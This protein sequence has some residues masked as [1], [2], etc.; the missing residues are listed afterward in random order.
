[1]LADVLAVEERV[2]AYLG[3]ARSRKTHTIVGLGFRWWGMFGGKGRNG[4]MMG[5]ELD[6]AF[7]LVEKW[8]IG[9]DGVTPPICPQELMLRWPT[10]AI[11]LRTRPTIDMIDGFTWTARHCGR[12][13]RNLT[14]R[15]IQIALWTEAA[16]TNSPMDFVRARGR[17]VQ[18]KG[19]MALD[20]VG[21]PNNWVRESVIEAAATEAEEIAAAVDRGETPE[22]RTY[23]V[24]G[25]DIVDNQWVD[26]LEAKAFKRDLERIDVRI[27]RREAGGEFI[28][29][30]EMVFDDVFDASRHT[31]D[32]G[33]ESDDELATSVLDELGFE[34][35]TEQVSVRWFTEPH[36]WV[37]A[38]DV[39][40]NPHT[41]LMGK[42]GVRKGQAPD[43]PKNW[44]AFYLDCLQ[45]F[46]KDTEQAADDL[47]RYRGGIYAGAAIVIDATSGNDRTNAGGALNARLKIIPPEAYRRAGFE[48]RGPEYQNDYVRFKNCEKFDGSIV[49][50][51][52]FRLNRTHINRRLCKP[53]TKALRR[54]EAEPDG[55]TPKKHSNTN[56]DRYVAAFT[57]V[58]RYHVWPFFA[59]K[60]YEESGDPLGVEVYG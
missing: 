37:L 16:T 15:N 27:A 24:K 44:H 51:R 9:E 5:P 1:M 14:A 22:R 49:C 26:Q 58:F 36:A 45:V 54:Q 28:G 50:R 17:V 40:K 48:V 57:D 31:F 7:L 4:W 41:A 12:Q 20:A 13:G 25:L 55:V 38:V 35:C 10:E 19:R 52:L 43:V 59:T 47:V 18:S 2:H 60:P 32:L 8:A 33:P 34:D 39:N 11:E 3:G 42:F 21:E 30:A 56:Q 6:R 46:G 29:D 23:R 53:F